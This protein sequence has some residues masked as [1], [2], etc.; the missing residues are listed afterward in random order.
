AKP[1]GG[2]F[3]GPLSGEFGRLGAPVVDS[4]SQEAL[5]LGAIRCVQDGGNPLRHGFSLIETRH[6]LRLGVLLPE[7][8]A[9][10][11]PRHAEAELA[12]RAAW[13]PACASEMIIST[14][15][16]PRRTKLSR[17]SPPMHFGF[18]QGDGHPKHPAMAALCVMET[19][20]G[21]LRRVDQLAAFAHPLMLSA[22]ERHK[23][24]HG[25]AARQTA[26][27]ASSCSAARLTCIVEIDTSGPKRGLQNRDLLAD[28]NFHRHGFGQGDI[29]GLL[30][31]RSL[32]GRWD[33]EAA[34][35]L[36]GTSKVSS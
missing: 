2:I 7:E 25:A 16:D 34:A 27:P 36:K 21:T 33:G 31:A 13:S 5:G 10:G 26:R 32:P 8:L 17:R 24:F 20:T 12:R 15:R 3:F 14:P 11:M 18:R 30:G 1:S 29:E 4:L 23:A 28:G 35:A 9:A 19:A 6:V 22:E